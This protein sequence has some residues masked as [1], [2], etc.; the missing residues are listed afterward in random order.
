[1][2]NRFPPDAGGRIDRQGAAQSKK[3]HWIIFP[4]SNAVD[5]FPTDR[6]PPLTIS[7]AVEAIGVYIGA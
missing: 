1:M 4:R 3:R 7:L 2:R 6:P 5:R